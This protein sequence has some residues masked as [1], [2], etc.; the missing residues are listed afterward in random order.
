MLLLELIIGNLSPI[1]TGNLLTLQF[2][3][4]HPSHTKSSIIFSKALRIRRI[5]LVANVAKL[6][7]S[8]K[9][10]VYPKGIRSARKQKGQ[11]KVIH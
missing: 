3:S 9:E 7:D 1:S 2:E 10:R 5:D 11:L 6:K 8:F 4:C